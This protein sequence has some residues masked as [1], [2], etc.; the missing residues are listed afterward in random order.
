MLRRVLTTALAIGLL[1]TT[2]A[3]AH[4]ATWNWNSQ[5]SPVSVYSNGSSGTL[6]GQGYG[7]VTLT[8][9]VSG[10]YWIVSYSG[11]GTVRDRQPGND[12]IYWENTVQVLGASN[13]D[14]YP[15]FREQGTRWNGSTWF[16]ST[17]THSLAL[18]SIDR[19][20]DIQRKVCEDR[21]FAGDPCRGGWRPTP[22]SF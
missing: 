21:R 8:G 14:A 1:A 15:A 12:S 11:A 10:G 18:G 9:R 19:R 4:A 22:L 17:R 16:R 6:L 13:P 5:S 7:S 2:P 20:A 3:A